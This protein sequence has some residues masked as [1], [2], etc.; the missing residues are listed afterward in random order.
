M[1]LTIYYLAA[2]LTVLTLAACGNDEKKEPPYESPTGPTEETEE[3]GTKTNEYL[4]FLQDNGYVE[5]AILSDDDRV[6]SVQFCTDSVRIMLSRAQDVLK[7]LLDMGE[8]DE[9]REMEILP[10]SGDYTAQG[11]EQYYKGILVDGGEYCIIA[12]GGVIESVSGNFY[13]V[14]EVDVTPR[15]TEKQALQYAMDYIGAESYKWQIPE[16][17]EKLKEHFGQEKTYFPSGELFI[18]KDWLITNSVYRLA[19]RFDIYAHEPGSRDFVD[20]DAI[21]GTILNKTSR[22]LFD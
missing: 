5:E 6:T 17:E 3:P 9:L 13:P 7:K 21:T 10:N 14:G 12:K 20:V 11:Y 1:K 16:E 4:Q 15:I 2:V 18:V 8:Y 22:I 19:Y